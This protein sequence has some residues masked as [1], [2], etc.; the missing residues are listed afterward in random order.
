MRPRMT[1]TTQ[2]SAHAGVAPRGD[3]TAD[4]ID[5]RYKSL[6]V[7]GRGGMGRVEVALERGPG[8]FERVV[9]LKRLLPEAARD[10]RHREMFLREARLAALLCHP[11]V[12][13]AFAYGDI[14]GELFIA[15]EY[16]EGQPLSNVV[17]A[18]RGSPDGR[19]EPEIVAYVLAE[20]C[21]GLHA[22]HELCDVGGRPLKVVH[23]DVSP[24]NVMVAYDGRIKLLDFGVAKLEASAHETR[25]GEVKG[26]MAY[27]S[28]EQALGEKLDRRSDLYSIGAVLFE[29]LTGRRMWGTGTDLEVLRRM[30][31]EG[32]PRLD[33]AIPGAPPALVELHTRLVARDPSARPLTALEVAHA[34]RAFASTTQITDVRSRMEGFFAAEAAESQGLLTKALV[35][36]APAEVEELRQSLMPDASEGLT[37]TEAVILRPQA[38]R[39]SMAWVGA[40]VVVGGVVVAATVLASAGKNKVTSRETPVA[41][42]PSAALAATLSPPAAKPDPTPSTPTADAV[43]TPKPSAPPPAVHEGSLPRAA[44][45]ATTPRV[46]PTP[47]TATKLPDV[48][49]KPF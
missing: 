39:G 38:K 31:L 23:R 28:P 16:V 21:E 45:A 5:D 41:S 20:A 18:A 35:D 33:E 29:C 15:M 6:F 32:P 48:D 22:A 49:P 13:H 8:G 19:L 10:P 2:V 37:R 12:V 27:M 43:P 30:A 46:K 14:Q 7:V 42:A 34:L 9:A 25:T 44:H 4:T 17:A 1:E 40:G 47:A 3:T 26:K 11:N 36:A 24:Q